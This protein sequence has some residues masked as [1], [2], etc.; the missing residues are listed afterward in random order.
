MTQ[1]FKRSLNYTGNPSTGDLDASLTLM[2]M[3]ASITL[4]R[5]ISIPTIQHSANAKS[6]MLNAQSKN[7]AFDPSKDTATGAAKKAMR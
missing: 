2:L 4:S 7:A 1:S 5:A 3:P 6:E